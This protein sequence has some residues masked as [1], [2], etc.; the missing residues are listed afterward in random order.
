MEIRKDAIVSLPIAAQADGTGTNNGST[1]DMLGFDNICFIAKFDDV[2]NTSVL[3]L[4]AQQGQQSDASDMVDLSGNATLTADATSGDN[5]M[6]L[7]DVIKPIERYVRP[8]VVIGT[9]NATLAGVIA[10]RYNGKKSP[11][12]ES[13]DVAN[14]NTIVSPAEA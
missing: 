6:L 4:K 3:T 12:T 2:D 14:S 7:L 11:V 8:V 5:K 10:I 9:A 1:I 13:S